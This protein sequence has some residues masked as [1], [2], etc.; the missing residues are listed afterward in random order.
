M[1]YSSFWFR[2]I[3][4]L[5]SFEMLNKLTCWLPLLDK[6][7]VPTAPLLARFRLWTTILKSTDVVESVA[8]LT[9]QRF[10]I[11]RHVRLMCKLLL[12][13]LVKENQRAILLL[14]SI[15]SKYKPWA[16]KP[17]IF[18]DN[19]IFSTRAWEDRYIMFINDTLWAMVAR[20]FICQNHRCTRKKI[21]IHAFDFR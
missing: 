4:P 20:F 1:F 18:Q 9:G 12:W 14:F 11:W 15:K 19:Q 17:R 7:L 3:F 10:S 8:R 5:I 16:M 13:K 2:R 21:D 6:R